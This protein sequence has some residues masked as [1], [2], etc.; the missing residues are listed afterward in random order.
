VLGPERGRHARDLACGRLDGRR[1]RFQEVVDG[2]PARWALAEWRNEDLGVRGCW[3]HEPVAPIAGSRHELAGTLMMRVV[4]V[5][6]RDQDAGIE[7]RQV[8]SRR[9]SSR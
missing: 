9:R 7:D 1:E 5:Q 6:D 3:D 8:H 2:I 4:P